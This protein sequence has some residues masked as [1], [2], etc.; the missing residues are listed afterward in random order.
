M[1]SRPPSPCHSRAGEPG[2]WAAAAILA[3]LLFAAADSLP[4]AADTASGKAA[5]AAYARLALGDRAGALPFLREAL[6]AAV[7]PERRRQLALDLGYA[8]SALER[9]VHA[10]D[11]FAAALAISVDARTLTAL[12]YARL[13]A[14][15]RAG[16]ITAF[17][18]AVARTPRDTLLLRQLGYLYKARGERARAATYF[19]RA[20]SSGGQG[21][22]GA[23]PAERDRL[24]REVRHLER[25]L[26]GGLSL[27]WR[28]DG[29]AG[30]RPLALG[31]RVLSQS[32]GMAEANLRLGW[33]EIG[34]GRWLAGFSRLIWRI[35]GASPRPADESLQAGFGIKAK[36]L[37]AQNLVLALER[38]VAVGRFA[39]DDWLARAAWSAGSGLEPPPG[40]DS[41]PMWHLYLDLAAIDFADPDLQFNAESRVGWGFQS[42][43]IRLIPHLLAASFVQDD[44]LGTDS[45]VEAGPALSLQLPLGGGPQRAPG[46]ALELRLAYRVKLAGS[47]RNADGPTLSLGFRF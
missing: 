31:S 2:R 3:T 28:D 16:A 34:A 33:P 46:A 21:A 19:R 25:R 47:A 35:G 42:G 7:E 26:W 45:L 17:E 44:A 13:A 8:L 18:R 11:A 36:P 39:R 41:W 15:D 5:K 10:A 32:Q 27:F 22:G 37:A 43:R 23:D 40:A 20:L 9:H 6:A 4:A 30:G 29:P 24:R 38:L 14:G 1:P 12:G